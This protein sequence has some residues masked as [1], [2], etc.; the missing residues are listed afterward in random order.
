MSARGDVLV[1]LEKVIGERE[2]VA[3]AAEAISPSPWMA[4]RGENA[5]VTHMATSDPES[6]L[7][8]CA[9]D[10]KLLKLHGGKMHSCPATDEADYLDEWTQFRHEDT[11]PVV[12]LIAEG[13]G[14][15][16]ETSLADAQG[17]TP[18]TEGD[19]MT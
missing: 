5:T 19:R 6:V 12:Q 8:R 4:G 10:R 7:R 15:A 11:C 14:W 18:P 3:R 1:W 17:Q 2:D 13:Y 16:E 9:V